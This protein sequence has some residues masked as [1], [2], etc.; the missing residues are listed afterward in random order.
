MYRLPQRQS[1]AAMFSQKPEGKRESSPSPPASSSFSSSVHGSVTTDGASL[2]RYT[3]TPSSST[4]RA[5]PFA[6]FGLFPGLTFSFFCRL[7]CSLLNVPSVVSL[8]SRFMLICT[9]SPVRELVR[10]AVSTT[11]DG[12][13][14]SSNPPRA[15]RWDQV[16]TFVRSSVSRTEMDGTVWDD[17]AEGDMDAG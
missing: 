14:V 13:D 5:S 8:G 16:T 10:C 7:S 1:A 17:S 9:L 11:V 6:C 3:A 12:F 15:V 4:S 2:L